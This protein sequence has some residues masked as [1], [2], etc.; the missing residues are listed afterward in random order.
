MFYMQ[1]SSANQS[2]WMVRTSSY[3]CRPSHI[4]SKNY[5]KYIMRAQVEDDIKKCLQ[6]PESIQHIT[7]ACR[8]LVPIECLSRHNQV[9]K[10][11]HQSLALI[12]SLPCKEYHINTTSLSWKTIPTSC[13]AINQYKQTVH[14]F[15]IDLTLPI[16]VGNPNNHNILTYQVVKEGNTRNLDRKSCRTCN[17]ESVPVVPLKIS[18]GV[19]PK[20]LT[21]NQKMLGTANKK[22]SIQKAVILFNTLIVRSFLS[23]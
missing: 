15:T 12:Y 20:S 13:T 17:K 4:A 5:R 10:I 22:A 9:A 23:G 14:N 1:V 19:I 2:E 3:I 16:I 8:T 6:Q 21:N 7:S 18:T 11:S